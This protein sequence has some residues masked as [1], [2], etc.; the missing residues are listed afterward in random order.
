[1]LNS[2]EN[3][4][5]C[6]TKTKTSIDEMLAEGKVHSTTKSGAVLLRDQSRY[7]TLVSQTGKKTPL[8]SYYEA[9]TGGTL[10]SGHSYETQQT[11]FREGDTEYINTRGG[12]RKAV[13]RW[14]PAEGEYTFTALFMAYT[15]GHGHGVAHVT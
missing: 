3:V 4:S 14:S 1:M 9:Q 10:D 7:H 6:R 11:P 12:A 8:G 13:R 15:H 5:K 2:L